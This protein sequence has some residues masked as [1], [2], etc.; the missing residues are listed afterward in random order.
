MKKGQGSAKQRIKSGHKARAPKQEI[1]KQGA[2]NN[3]ID[4]PLKYCPT[5]RPFL[6]RYG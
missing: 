3:E 6:L 2:V 5:L 4:K 1:Q